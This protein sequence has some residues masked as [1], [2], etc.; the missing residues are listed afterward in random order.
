[1]LLMELPARVQCEHCLFTAQ[2]G[3]AL[4]CVEEQ[5]GEQILS[6]LVKC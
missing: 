5:P 6:A 4:P 1:M 2:E 3:S